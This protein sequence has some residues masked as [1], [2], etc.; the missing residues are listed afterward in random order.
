[1][2]ESTTAR[3][4]DGRI[5]VEFQRVGKEERIGMDDKTEDNRE[6]QENNEG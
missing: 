3:T 4:N 5:M 1:M 6:T 2:K